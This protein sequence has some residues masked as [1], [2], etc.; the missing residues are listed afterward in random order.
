MVDMRCSDCGVEV[1][2]I[3]SALRREIDEEMRDEVE[4]HVSGLTTP[5]GKRLVIAD[6]TGHFTCPVCGTVG[7]APPLTPD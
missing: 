7:V 5:D 1:L 2:V 3:P 4:A 6:E